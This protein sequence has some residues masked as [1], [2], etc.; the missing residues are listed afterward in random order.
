ML[1]V[2]GEV[3]LG[4]NTPPQRRAEAFQGTLHTLS[5]PSPAGMNTP[6]PSPPPPQP[7]VAFTVRNQPWGQPQTAP[8]A[9]VTGVPHAPSWVNPRGPG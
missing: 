8:E 9:K 7:T 2:R 6:S 5:T 4:C 1:P 3:S